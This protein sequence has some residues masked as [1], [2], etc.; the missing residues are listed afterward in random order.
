MADVTI[1]NLSPLTPSTGLVLPVSN[2]TNTGK[3]TLAEVC[4]VMTSTQIINALGYTPYNGASNPNGYITASSLPSGSIIQVKQIVKTDSA[5]GTSTTYSDVPGMSISIT[6]SKTT[7]KI[8][9][10]VNASIVFGTYGGAVKLQ[11]NNNDI[12]VGTGGTENATVIGDSDAGDAGTS[13]LSRSPFNTMNTVYLHSPNTTNVVT[14]KL[15][16]KSFYIQPSPRAGDYIYLGKAVNVS[17]NVPSSIT[18]MEIAG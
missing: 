18:L 11:A 13:A 6:P 1:N 8:L 14:Y 16:W 5:V 15:V 9:V 4:G 17:W 7:S 12:Y 2:G 3:V 10:M